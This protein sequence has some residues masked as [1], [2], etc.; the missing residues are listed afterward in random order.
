MR[1]IALFSSYD[2]Q[3]FLVLA[4]VFSSLSLR[5]NVGIADTAGANPAQPV[6]LE[7]GANLVLRYAL[8]AHDG[9]VHDANV[10]RRYADYVQHSC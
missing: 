7:E 4:G 5:R 9:D 6:L 2:L 8:F 1:H 10:G 3:S